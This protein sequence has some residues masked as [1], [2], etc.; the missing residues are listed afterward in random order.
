MRKLF[1]ILILFVCVSITGCHKSSSPILNPNEMASLLADIHKSESVMDINRSDYRND[2]SKLAIRE[3]VF[4]RH[5]VTQEIFDTSMNWYAHNMDEY[6]KVYDK[7]IENLQQ[8]IDKTDAIAARIQIVA[9]GDSADIW[10]LSKRYVVNSFSPEK[11]FDFE[12]LP[13]ENW[14]KGDN[15]TLNFKVLNALSPIS[16]IIIAEYADGQ[17]EWTENNYKDNGN[18]SINLMSDS[19]RTL[20]KVYGNISLE[21]QDQETIFLDSISLFRT[22]VTSNNYSIRHNLKK[23]KISEKD[24][25]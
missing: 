14:E 20:S 23:T 21:P 18:V 16:A 10:A 13:D 8:Q 5:N 6:M 22:R 11:S 19:T 9:T 7:V 4:R 24:S 17:I 1:Y 15:Y 12:L 3:A 25:I 2:T